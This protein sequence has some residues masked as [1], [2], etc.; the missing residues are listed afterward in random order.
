LFACRSCDC[1]GYGACERVSEELDAFEVFLAVKVS[2]DRVSCFEV[3]LIV[4]GFH[5]YFFCE[6]EVFQDQLRQ[7]GAEVF[8]VHF[9]D[10]GS[11]CFFNL[12]LE[13]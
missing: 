6:L 2:V 11:Q 12:F 9:G 8:E 10:V 3:D 7:C 5:F 13:A 4:F 1:A